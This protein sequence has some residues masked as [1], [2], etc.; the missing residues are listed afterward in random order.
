MQQTSKYQF[1]LIDS[2]DTFSPAP[3]NDNME[4]VEEALGAVDTAL[5]EKIALA[6]TALGSG[7]Q[8]ARIVYGSF[9]GT[10]YTSKT[11][12]FEFKPLL[13]FLTDP[14]VTSNSVTVATL[15]RPISTNNAVTKVVWTDN[16]VTYGNSSSC[17]YNTSGNTIYYCA[18]GISL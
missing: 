17:A 7:G 6:M 5:D 18:V 13:V 11:I 2:G 14:A 1:N 8:T 3:L 4:K 9:A 16:S 12:S 10:G 15:I